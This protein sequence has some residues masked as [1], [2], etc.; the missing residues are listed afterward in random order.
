MSPNDK[1]IRKTFIGIWMIHGTGV[2]LSI[3][4]VLI[5]AVF[6][7]QFLGPEA[8][9]AAGLVN[10]ITLIVN[11]L[12]ALI[13]SGLGI[14][15]TRFM[16][17]AKLDMVNKVFSVV[18]TVNL[19]ISVFCTL[20]LF[21][22]APGI[23]GALG[24]KTGS[25]EI[26][27]MTQDYLK[28]YALA[29]VPLSYS[30]GLS[31][32]MI[33]DNDRARGL[34]T[35]V[36]TLLS[37]V[38]FDA[39]NVTVFHGGMFGMALATALSQVV[40]CAVV[41][42][43]FLRKDRMLRFSSKGLDLRLMKD[44]LL[45]GVPNSVSVGSIAVKVMI[46]NEFMLTISTSVAVA[47]FSAANSLFTVVNSVCLGFYLTASSLVSFLF[48]EEDRNGIVKTLKIAVRMSM[49]IMFVISL[50]LFIFSRGAA[51]LL[52]D[53]QATEQIEFASRFIR[54][55]ALQYLFFVAAF[56]L[57]GVY[58]GAGKNTLNYIFVG[59]REGIIPVACS[60]GLGL[61]FGIK[62]FEAGLALSGLLTL[63][64]CSIIPSIVNKRLSLKYDDV[65]LIDKDFGSKEDDLFEASMRSMEEVSAVSDEVIRFCRSRGKDKKLAN[66]AALCIEEMAG[67][68]ITY[69]ME[70][71]KKV[72]VDIRVICHP[73]SMV[74]RIRDDGAP[75][76]PLTWYKLNNS[77][78]PEVG[79][80]IRL[81]MG[82]AK[83]VKY[84]PAMGLNSLMISL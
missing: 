38:L 39:L 61:A 62:G 8:V 80:G 60:I 47:G 32:L 31:G 14:V 73:D 19:F 36:A 49:T 59:L 84:I 54:M 48:G 12:M 6:T 70:K 79:L 7:G 77:D 55:M 76:D 37:D 34:L 27:Q 9:A 16:G 35:M 25:P 21:F 33:L 13:G 69:G 40:G 56:P 10:P 57:S 46:F 83:D 15:C 20:L 11:M 52:L 71:G 30:L 75:F 66:N 68:S 44:V 53:A 65:V 5:D 50:A 1:L 67:N 42:S 29:I 45:S 41:F 28:G 24:A 2:L 63:L 78:D 58:Q 43:H 3:A 74:I 17:M 51:R 64:S 18:M 4:C 26:I 82:L 72:N 81:I 22:A 23:A